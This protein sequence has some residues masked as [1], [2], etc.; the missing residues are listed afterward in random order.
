MQQNTK[1]LEVC[2]LY[3]CLPQVFPV[4][5]QFYPHSVGNISQSHCLHGDEYIM[6]VSPSCLVAVSVYL[7]SKHNNNNNNRYLLLSLSPPPTT[8][9]AFALCLPWQQCEVNRMNK[10]Y[11]NPPPW[12]MSSC[13]YSLMGKH[14]A[15]LK[16]QTVYRIAPIK[17]QPGHLVS[18]YFISTQTLAGLIQSGY[19]YQPLYPSILWMLRIT[20]SIF[21]LLITFVWEFYTIFV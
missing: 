12:E 4:N 18:L 1:L 20:E 5:R 15:G 9:W 21:H 16:G 17:M 6:Y 2:N 8:L 3:T 14:R 11:Q 19:M 13:Q 7:S 10:T